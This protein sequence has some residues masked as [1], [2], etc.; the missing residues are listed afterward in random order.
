M[1]NLVIKGVFMV[2][3]LFISILIVACNNKKNEEEKHAQSADISNITNHKEGLP[4]VVDFS[5]TW[6]GPCRQFA[7]T[8]E[9]VSAQYKGKAEFMSIDIDEHPE[10]ATQY[11]IEA[12][13]TIIII[14]AKGELLNKFV[15]VPN[16]HE[17]TNAI[18]KATL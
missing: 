5:A 11:E 3:Y 15:G 9:K 17:F 13:P 10:L 7:P 18:E 4:L 14:S 1:K 6:C 16:I 2:S 8:F 12:V